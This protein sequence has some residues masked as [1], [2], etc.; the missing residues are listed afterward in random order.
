MAAVA[1]N[2]ALPADPIGAVTAMH[3]LLADGLISKAQYDS[4]KAVTLG[5][6]A[7][8]A[9]AAR[10][11]RACAEGVR[12]LHALRQELLG[13][14]QPAAADAGPGAQA[15]AGGALAQASTA[16]APAAS[17]IPPLL[18][19]KEYDAEL[20][21]LLGGDSTGGVVKLRALL[22]ASRALLQLLDAAFR[23]S[24]PG[25]RRASAP[26]DAEAAGGPSAPPAQPG[27][28]THV[29]L[30]RRLHELH[31]R[32]LVGLPGW[33]AAEAAEHGLR[34]ADVRALHGLWLEG[35]LSEAEYGRE[36]EKTLRLHSRSAAVVRA[37]ELREAVRLCAAGVLDATEASRAK[38]ALLELDSPFTALGHAREPAA[39]LRP[40]S[41]R[42]LYLAATL[43]ALDP[44]AER[45]LIGAAR[46]EPH[47]AAPERHG[48][49]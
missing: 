38:R 22:A 48:A 13:P 25:A 33:G 16:L 1:P 44:S 7:W 46:L 6:R 11:A 28:S 31:K 35:S 49:R 3:G 26:A 42:E 34:L 43:H 39:A 2:G 19:P 29:A 17:G 14:P 27:S 23:P 30:V 32:V 40:K 20:S 12:A 47:A 10:K 24:P 45:G 8:S 5:D 37:A 9:A 4:Y 18:S 41:S 15:A 21:K 36:L